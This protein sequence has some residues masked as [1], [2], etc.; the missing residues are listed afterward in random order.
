MRLVTVFDA[1][2]MIWPVQLVV[3]RVLNL[4]YVYIKLTLA[5]RG[6]KPV[7]SLVRRK[8]PPKLPFVSSRV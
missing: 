5:D 2:V 4:R 3:T 6:V 1:V 8:V 7:I